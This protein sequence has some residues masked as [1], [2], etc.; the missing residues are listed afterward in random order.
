MKKG[1][2]L[3][4][5]LISMLILGIVIAGIISVFL[6][7]QR[8][9]MEVQNISS[10]HTDAQV[11]FEIIKWDLIM[12]GFGLGESHT[13]I[14]AG[15]GG[16]NAPDT[17]T[18][19]GLT[20]GYEL[21]TTRFNI[22]IG[23]SPTVDNRLLCN[24]WRGAD[25]IRNIRKGLYAFGIDPDTRDIT[26]INGILVESTYV[27]PIDTSFVI[28]LRTPVTYKRG[29]VLI[30]VQN[31]FIPLEGVRYFVDENR[32]LWRNNVPFLENVE[33]I[34]FAYGI[35]G[36]LTEPDG[37]IDDDEWVNDLDGITSSQILNNRFAIRVT[38]IVRSRG[39]PGFNY[40]TNEIRI[41]NRVIELSHAD[42]IFDRIILQGVVYPR[43]LNM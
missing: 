14:L 1:F 39:I 2:T 10:M 23:G 29:T 27:D 42:R 13:F 5:I 21:A 17:I 30:G 3:V 7:Q 41:E 9:T 43:N 24:L 18:L 38:L 34:Q 16:E 4:E 37:E 8:K 25:S 31:P 40:P 11:A 15:D 12:A 26:E 33:D 32:T 36:L 19:F 28:F 35:D 20:L 22:V 6:T